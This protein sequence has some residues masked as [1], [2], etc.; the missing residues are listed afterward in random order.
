MKKNGTLLLI[1]C[2]YLMAGCNGLSSGKNSS[3]SYDFDV[4]VASE[5]VGGSACS[6][7]NEI[8]NQDFILN[9]YCTADQSV[10]YTVT[11]PDGAFP[12]TVVC[13]SNGVIADNT[14]QMQQFSDPSSCATAAD[15]N[16]VHC[17]WRKCP[18][19]IEAEQGASS[20]QEEVTFVYK[21]CA[22]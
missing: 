16:D 19:A 1:S 13:P 8:E 18:I 11:T 17:T 7:S 20:D 4:M 10:S 3:V 9:I 15:P 14:L 21:A 12:T 22:L 2:F 5:C 6:T